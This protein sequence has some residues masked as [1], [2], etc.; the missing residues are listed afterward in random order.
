M[1]KDSLYAAK[2]AHKSIIS[3]FRVCCLLLA[4]LAAAMQGCD[5]EDTPE[6]SSPAHVQAS[7]PTYPRKLEYLPACN[8][9]TGDKY[10]IYGDGF[11]ERDS[12]FLIAPDGQ[13]V[14][15]HATGRMGSLTVTVPP[16]IESGRYIVCLRREML[17]NSLVAVQWNV[18][19]APVQWIK[20][21]VVAHQGWHND[22]IPGNSLAA[23]RAALDRG[24]DWIELDV[25]M[26]ADNELV[27]YHDEQVNGLDIQSSTL[28]Q[29]CG[30]QLENGEPMPGFE[31]YLSVFANHPNAGKSRLLVEIKPQN[32][33]SRT[34]DCTDAVLAHTRRLPKGWVE[35]ISFSYTACRHVADCGYAAAYLQGD[36]SPAEACHDGLAG[37]DYQLR[38]WTGHPEWIDEAR[39]LGL[40]TNVWRIDANRE[41]LQC[42]SMGLDRITTDE[43]SNLS[44]HLS[45]D[46]LSH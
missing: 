45:R 36:V 14:A 11:R 39:A 15:C 18:Q 8:V 19:S 21:Q 4:I 33:V 30:P 40:H 38:D 46:Y 24:L 26:T 28:A 12:A 13:Q 9:C 37:L 44:R 43:V 27:V 5:K 20:P 16:G 6:A 35:F 29:L 42:I 31:Q 22:E 2:G 34:L 25:W 10:T 17:T 32:D 3:R 1:G 23:L 41:M 7:G